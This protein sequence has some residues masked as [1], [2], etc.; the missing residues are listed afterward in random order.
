[1]HEATPLRFNLLG[2]AIPAGWPCGPAPQCGQQPPSPHGGAA[3]VQNGTQQRAQRTWG[4]R[5]TLSNA[6]STHVSAERGPRH[7]LMLLQLY[8]TF[9]PAAD[10]QLEAL[11]R[12]QLRMQQ[13]PLLF[14]L[15]IAHLYR[16]SS[17]RWLPDGGFLSRFQGCISKLDPRASSP[18][19]LVDD[20]CKV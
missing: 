19:S 11:H 18:C 4:P 6:H 8:L 10:L 1:M 9:L 15:T 12:T 7:G 3:A 2:A 14:Q 13:G 17:C 20:N 16:N 5:R